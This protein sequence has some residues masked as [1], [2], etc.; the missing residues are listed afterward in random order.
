V[1]SV[2]DQGTKY[3]AHCLDYRYLFDRKVPRA[4]IQ[5]VC[6][7]SLFDPATC[8]V[9]RQAWQ[10]TAVITAINSDANP[11]TVTVQPLYPGL[12]PS[13]YTIPNFFGGGIFERGLGLGFEPRTITQSSSDVPDNL[14]TLNL[15]LPLWLSQVGD[16]VQITAGC[17]GTVTA[18]QQFGN[19]N[20][21]GGFPA[22][23]RRNLTLEAWE[24]LPVTQGGKK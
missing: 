7:Y 23:P 2:E 16:Q 18:C 5:E 12:N 13:W 22:I 15:N 6:N 11:P 4:L 14:L 9:V 24:N 8:G 20:R 1:R 3:I 10:T 17:A 21:F 19:Y